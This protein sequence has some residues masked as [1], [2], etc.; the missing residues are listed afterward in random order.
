MTSILLPRYILVKVTGASYTPF[1]G[2]SEG[3]DVGVQVP[4]LRASM[5]AARVA[6]RAGGEEAARARRGAAGVPEVQI[7]VLEQAA[8]DLAAHSLVFGGSIGSS[9][10]RGRGSTGAST[11]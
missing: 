6:G 7:A 2:S 3:H 4:A 5:G 1:R 8:E 9:T 10:P 11:V